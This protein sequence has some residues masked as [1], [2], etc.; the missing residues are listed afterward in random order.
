MLQSPI[1][2]FLGF[3]SQ[4]P[5]VIGSNDCLDVGRKSSATRIQVER[6]IREVNFDALVNEFAEVSPIL[7]VSGAPV[8]LVDY[9]AGCF[10][11]PQQLQHLVPDG[12][13]TLGRRLSFFEPLEKVQAGS[14]GMA[15]YRFLLF[16]QGY[17]PLTLASS[18]DSDVPEILVQIF[19]GWLGLFGIDLSS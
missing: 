3:F 7:E 10:S 11:I 1:D 8:N 5:D 12:T 9:D 6:F 19:G 15:L 4:I 17:A 16:R 13:A 2:A 14:R 18:R